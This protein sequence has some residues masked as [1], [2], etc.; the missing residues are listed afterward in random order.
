MSGRLCSA[1]WFRLHVAVACMDGWFLSVAWTYCSLLILHQFMDIWGL[2]WVKP[3]WTLGG[4]CAHVQL[5][6]SSL[7]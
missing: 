5:P 1:Q 2:C 4:L 7:L 6:F 3:L